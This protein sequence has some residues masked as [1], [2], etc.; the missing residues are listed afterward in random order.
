MEARL[1]AHAS[2][3]APLLYW[4]LPLGSRGN[5]ARWET[6]RI[7]PLLSW[8]EISQ[9]PIAPQSVMV[10]CTVTVTLM[11]AL[12][13]LIFCQPEF[14]KWKFAHLSRSSSG[15]NFISS[16][17]VSPSRSKAA[18]A[19]RKTIQS[20]DPYIITIM[21]IISSFSLLTLLN[22]RDAKPNMTYFL[23]SRY[24]ESNKR[25]IYK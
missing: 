2:Y 3:L 1:G 13:L 15:D 18:K 6:G 4:N 14:S 19:T 21:V 10:L 25:E 16:S 20:H 17:K 22:N 9:V 8:G 11:S 12:K 7:F 5:K 24:S 23:V